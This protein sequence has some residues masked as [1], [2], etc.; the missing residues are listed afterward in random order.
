MLLICTTA[1]EGDGFFFFF[2]PASLDSVW[3]QGGQ[4]SFSQACSPTRVQASEMIIAG[5]V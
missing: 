4:I 2:P 1:V 5:V 3:F